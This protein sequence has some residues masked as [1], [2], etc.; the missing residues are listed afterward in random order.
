M[1]S[2]ICDRWDL[3]LECIR[4]YYEGITDRENNLI[5][6]TLEAD[7]LFFDMFVD[8]RGYC[9]FFFLQDCV[10]EDYRTVKMWI[11]AEPFT[12][13]YPYSDTVEKYFDGIE[14]YLSFDRS[15]NRRIREYEN[16]GYKKEQSLNSPRNRGQK[17]EKN[18]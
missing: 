8:F 5:G 1:T 11:P 9:D 13:K 14:Q 3:S 10:S 17:R 2:F 6:E 18:S 12:Q 15:R 7:N 16:S 4:R